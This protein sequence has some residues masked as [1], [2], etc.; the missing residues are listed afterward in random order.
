MKTT[1]LI[2][3]TTI[4][5]LTSSCSVMMAAKQEGVELGELQQCTTRECFL[6]YN[7]EIIDKGQVEDGSY[8]ETYKYRQRTGSIARA[9]MHGVLDLATLGLWEIAGTPIEGA[10][11][12]GKYIVITV[13]YNPDNT[14]KKVVLK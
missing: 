6:S 7:P 5:F 13:Y 1:P 14:V 2:V 10:K 3:F 9:V 12:K 11:Q 4:A 8:Y